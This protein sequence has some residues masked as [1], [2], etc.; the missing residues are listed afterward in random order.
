MVKRLHRQLKPAIKG[1]KTDAWTQ[2]LSIIL[3]G[4]R[5]AVEEDI[6]ATPAELV[7]GKTIRLPGQFLEAQGTVQPTNDFV[8]QLHKAMIELQPQLRR[9]RQ[10]TTFMHKNLKEAKKVFVRQDISV[11][12]ALQPSYEGPC[13]SKKRR[14]SI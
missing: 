2:V 9:H 10:R 13:S 12:R 6:N 4:I 5:A 8:S 7:F 1:H 3:M 14:K 11:T